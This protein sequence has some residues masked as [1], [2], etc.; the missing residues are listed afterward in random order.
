MRKAEVLCWLHESE[1]SRLGLLWSLADEARQRY[2]GDGVHLRG[3]IE[4]SN[5]CR[6]RCAYCGI[7]S[8]NHQLERYRMT[9]NEI[10]GCA[11]EAERF[12]YGTVVIQAGED[13]GLS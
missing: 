13:K 9:E 6:R 7:A 12:G 4:I 3:L 10:L 8:G 1:S 2:V 11:A 5:I